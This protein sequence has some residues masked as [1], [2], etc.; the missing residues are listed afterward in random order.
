MTGFTVISAI[1]LDKEENDNLIKITN[2]LHFH[3]NNID[4][5]DS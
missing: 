3:G 4:N 1:L 5:C 2:K